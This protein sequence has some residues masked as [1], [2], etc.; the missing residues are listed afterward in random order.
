MSVGLSHVVHDSCTNPTTVQYTDDHYPIFAK[1]GPV[2]K[3]AILRSTAI[4]NRRRNLSEIEQADRT[5]LLQRVL[6]TFAFRLLEAQH[7]GR[8]PRWQGPEA[9]RPWSGSGLGELLAAM[10]ISRSLLA[11]CVH[12]S[13]G[14]PLRLPDS[15]QGVSRR[16]IWSRAIGRRLSL[17]GL[18]PAGS[19]HWSE[20]LCVSMRRRVTRIDEYATL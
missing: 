13:I 19:I 8:T 20:S 11:R 1:G 4:H 14:R 15:V 3:D 17:A 10:P 12:V 7:L 6:S 5:H 9:L 16:A 18:L 2:C